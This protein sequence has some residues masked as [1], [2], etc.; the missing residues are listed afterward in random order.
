MSLTPPG[1][2]YRWNL[3]YLSPRF[4][5][6]IDCDRIFFLFKAAY[7]LSCI[8]TKFCFSIHS[9]M[10]IWVASTSWLL[11]VMLS[12]TLVCR[13][14]FE[15]LLLFLLDMYSE[16]RLLGHVAMVLLIFWETIMLFFMAIIPFCYPASHSQGFQCL[17]LPTNIC[18]LPGFFLGGVLGGIVAILMGGRWYL[19]EILICIS[20]M[21]NDVRNLF[22]YLLAMCMSSVET[23]LYN[24]P[25]AH[26]L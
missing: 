19:L 6:V 3:Q 11:W 24:S 9:L 20:L 13:Y 5:C 4:F 2:S 23:C 18:Y 22:M 10:D 26:F 15:S 16:V 25:L 17:H 21:I 1:T 8:Y 12:W 14:L 7:I